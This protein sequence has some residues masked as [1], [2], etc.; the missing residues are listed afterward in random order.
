M[1]SASLLFETNEAFLF[2]TIVRH[3]EHVQCEN[4]VVHRTTLFLHLHLQTLVTV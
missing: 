4:L 3:S 2:E 1:S